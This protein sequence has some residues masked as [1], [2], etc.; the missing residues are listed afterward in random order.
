MAEDIKTE[1]AGRAFGE[2]VENP[3]FTCAEDDAEW[4][5]SSALTPETSDSNESGSE[6]GSESESSLSSSSSERDDRAL[7][8]NE[9]PASGRRPG[10]RWADTS[11]G[12]PVTSERPPAAP[13]RVDMAGANARLC[14][15]C[16]GR[17]VR[18]DAVRGGKAK[19][20]LALGI[21]KGER[22]PRCSKGGDV[23]EVAAWAED[24]LDRLP[25]VDGE[26]RITVE[27]ARKYANRVHAKEKARLE[28]SLA[29]AL[30][31]AR[32]AEGLL[33][34]FRRLA[35]HL[36]EDARATIEARRAAEDEAA[37]GRRVRARLEA[38]L[39]ELAGAR[40]AEAEAAEAAAER[41]EER[42]RQRERHDAERENRRAKREA[43]EAEKAER[44]ARRVKGVGVRSE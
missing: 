16:A 2:G 17:P 34:D 6:S 20:A 43:R 13:G 27:S 11:A 33:A 7:S 35:A 42:K 5:A 32:I 1:I 37:K 4:R 25:C 40:A 10:G 39:A 21:A 18:E 15:G 14:A 19:N 44:A 22:L 24:F 29:E 28:A 12:A 3:S 26:G 41:R 9:T 8:K 36:S 31:R 38:E 30:E 23:C